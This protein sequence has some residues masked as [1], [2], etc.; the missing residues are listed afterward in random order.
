MNPSSESFFSHLLSVL[1]ANEGLIAALA[2]V[3]GP[4]LVLTLFVFIMRGAGVSLRP[5]WVF[6]ALIGP[7]ALS[8]VITELARARDPSAMSAPAAGLDIRDDRFVDRTLI[9]GPDVPDNLMRDAK[10]G[11]AGILD[12]AEVA[13]AGVTLS[14]ET[15]LVAQ[16]PSEEQAKRASAAYHRAYQLRGVSGDAVRGWRATRMQGDFIEMLR[17]GRHLFVWTGLT[18]E[19]AAARRA[20]TSLTSH[21]PSLTTSEL[22]ALIPALQ[23]VRTFFEPAWIKVLGLLFMVAL[24]TLVFFKGAA[25][26]S[27]TV[28]V[29]GK[30]VIPARDLAAR[31]LSI[32]DLDVPFRITPGNAP[33]EYI[34][35]WR[36]ADAKWMDHARAHGLRRT[37]RICLTLDE[38]AH[39]VRATDHTSSFDWS[40]GRIGASLAWKT[41]L[42][43]VCFQKEQRSV[44]GLQFDDH[45][46]FKPE[47][48]YF[49]RF[50]LSEMKSPIIAAVTQSGWTWRPTVWQGPTWLRWLTE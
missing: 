25:W 41:E 42:G 37:F 39:T 49:Y 13:E 19:A 22:P 40:A 24:Y 47:L 45:G 5:I 43:L 50:D 17:A 1:R 33:G 38:A 27:S 14:G 11:M 44:F 9:F 15:I 3:V 8:F 35:D 21:F 26:A 46:R 34:A 29:A 7:I 36:Y 48:S 16:F 18:K 23:G 31:L 32:N 28:P 20:A 2:L 12:E 30:A 6:A 4:A 10:A